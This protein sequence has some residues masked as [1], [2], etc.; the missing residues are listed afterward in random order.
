MQKPTSAIRTGADLIG[1][2]MRL[3][4]PGTQQRDFISAI[5]RVAALTG[6]DPSR[7]N[8]DIPELR[9]D[10]NA[11]RPAKWGLSKKSFANSEAGLEPR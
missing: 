10:L 11:I 1:H 8:L 6:R 3:G 5:N 9:R 2:I 4:T 7:L